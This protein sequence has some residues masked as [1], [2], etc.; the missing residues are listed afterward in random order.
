VTDSEK[1]M[2]TAAS[3]LLDA[4]PPAVLAQARFPFGAPVRAQWSYLPGTRRGAE[5]AV[6]G[7]AARKAAHR[8]LATALSRPAFAQ[9]VTIMAFEELLDLD[10]AG[11]LGRHS[12]GYYVALFGEP[13]SRPWGW[14]FEGHHLSVNVTVAGGRPVVAPLFLGS[15]P[16]RV[17]REG[18][19]VIAPLRVE[20]DL[21][22]DLIAGLRP[23]LR[24]RAI[25]AGT[26]PDDIVTAMTETADGILEPPGVAAADLPGEARDALSRLLRVYT[27]R[28]APDLAEAALSAAVPGHAGRTR[29]GS[30]IPE[31]GIASDETTF[32][33]AGGLAPGAPHYYRIQAP[34]LLV[35]YDN[36]QRRSNHAHTVLR[37]PGRDFGA[38]LLSEH[39]T[40]EHP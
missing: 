6:L 13:G 29:S 39:L 36:T 2:V 27:G 19:L 1:T 28:L 12:D 17:E 15:N 16:A 34:G 26:A 20:E 7:P 22:R 5:L 24:D 10:E 40:A 33:W 9:A 37:M 30:G 25:I 38:A 23:A 14:R 4:C 21:A 18:E 35:E 3:D 8:L 32:A 31:A 11:A